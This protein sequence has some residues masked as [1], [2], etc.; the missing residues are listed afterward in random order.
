[1]PGAPLILI[2]RHDEFEEIAGSIFWLNGASALICAL[3]V[4]IAAPFVAHFSRSRS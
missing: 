3:V 4:V 1:M 2:Q